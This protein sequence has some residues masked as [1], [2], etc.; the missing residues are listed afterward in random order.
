MFVIL[1]FAPSKS[2]FNQLLLDWS[3]SIIIF[4]YN[5]LGVT[6]SVL[7]R[8]MTVVSPYRYWQYFDVYSPGY[9]RALYRGNGIKMPWGN[10]RIIT[11]PCNQWGVF[12]MLKKPG[13]LKPFPQISI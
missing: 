13:K 9:L 6:P 2:I 7:M 12:K 1:F 10:M 11:N 3:E 5:K 4:S 8:R